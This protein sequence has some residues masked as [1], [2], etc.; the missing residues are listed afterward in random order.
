MKNWTTNKNLEAAGIANDEWRV[1][2][3]NS[4]PRRK[5]NKEVEASKVV[6]NKKQNNLK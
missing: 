4:I 5:K 1:R 3:T 6:L 2:R